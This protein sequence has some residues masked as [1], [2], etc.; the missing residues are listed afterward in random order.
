MRTFL[1]ALLIAL[2][3]NATARGEVNSSELT[4][5]SPAFVALSVKDLDREIAWFNSMF[6]TTTQRVADIPGGRGRVALLS[7]GPLLVELISLNGSITPLEKGNSSPR[8]MVLGPVKTGIFVSNAAD[9]RAA[10]ESA[11]AEL[12]GDLFEDPTFGVLA[13]QVKDPEGNVIQIFQPRD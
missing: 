8:A 13:F 9:A 6:G 5:A 12:Y 1:I 2:S 10:L 11:G 7:N 4:I 3:P